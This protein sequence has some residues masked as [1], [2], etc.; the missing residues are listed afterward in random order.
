MKKTVLITA[1]G[2]MLVGCAQEDIFQNNGSGYA[3][4]EIGV[5]AFVPTATR[6]VAY[7]NVDEMRDN[8]AGFDLF[9]FKTADGSQFM[10]SE[11]DGIEF[12]YQDTRWYY[13]QNNEIRFWSE[14]E[15]GEAL[16][17]YAIS[18][19]DAPVDSKNIAAGTQTI[20]FTVPG[21]SENQFDLMYAKTT[22]VNPDATHDDGATIKENGIALDF[23]HALSQILFAAKTKHEYI[24]ADIES[25][26]ICGVKNSGTF[27]FANAPFGNDLTNYDSEIDNPWTLTD[28]TTD[29]MAEITEP[30]TD[31]NN[32][33]IDYE[34]ADYRLS[35]TDSSTAL[36]LLPQ[37]LTS[38]E[39]ADNSVIAEGAYFAVSC[40]VLYQNEDMTYHNVFGDEY[41]VDENGKYGYKTLYVPVPEES[42]WKPGYKYVY[43]FV[44]GEDAGT[45]ITVET[46]SVAEWD[47]PQGGD[48]PGQE[49]VNALLLDINAADMFVGDK[50]EVNLAASTRSSAALTFRL[51]DE[52]SIVRI[53]EYNEIEAMEPGQTTVYVSCEGYDEEATVEINVM[54]QVQAADL[55]DNPIRTV[56]ISAGAFIMGN[57]YDS[58]NLWNQFSNA[59]AHDAY[60]NE[61]FY[62]GQYE[63]SVAQFLEFIN[64]NSEILYIEDGNTVV[65]GMKS[66]GESI[67]APICKMDVNG[68]T[69]GAIG[70]LTVSDEAKD[71]PVICSWEGA[72]MFAKSVG[73]VDD[74]FYCHVP[75]EE[76]WEY[77]ARAGEQAR[78]AWWHNSDLFECFDF[79]DYEWLY[80]SNIAEGSTFEDVIAALFEC[81][82][83]PYKEVESIYTTSNGEDYDFSSSNEEFASFEFELKNIGT[84]T[85]ANAWGLYDLFGNAME[86]CGNYFYDY[87]GGNP[88]DANHVV[89]GSRLSLTYY[90]D[91][92]M[93]G[94]EISY[95]NELLNFGEF[96][97]VAYRDIN[98]E[99]EDGAGFRVVFKN[100][101]N[102]S[103]QSV[104]NN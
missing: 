91:I 48:D 27:D 42:V 101:Y 76:E 22:D 78:R 67:S 60:I 62:I 13:T 33:E 19:A 6:G 68:I 80:T 87:N 74:Q 15:D 5:R 21:N 92:Y 83:L 55:S 20:D 46:I 75:H 14:L 64:A 1:A 98:G 3:N 56:K 52:E 7:D 69:G 88:D 17:F 70:S 32:T 71:L 18:P 28:V 73:L 102:G 93:N 82:N 65:Y 96:N 79:E 50:I 57:D 104:Q 49:D 36:L 94:E 61:D 54:P 10:G 59:P 58:E 103:N 24:Y 4:G 11:S 40:R 35:I 72:A 99:S 100:G 95:V 2:L 97:G 66:E 30:V 31:I 81:E 85:R 26:T 12:N 90:K 89:R 34:D 41:N 16:D 23:Y 37:A 45:P 38:A 63:V 84:T 29:F 44:F 53:T 8:G 39:V 51:E 43:T 9:A 47:D 77:A 25:I 86:W